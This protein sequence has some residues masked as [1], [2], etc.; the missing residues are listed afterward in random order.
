MAAHEVRSNA[1]MNGGNG[2]GE[3]DGFD[4]LAEIKIDLDDIIMRRRAAQ[5]PIDAQTF[6]SWYS[7]MSAE[8]MARNGGYSVNACHDAKTLIPMA[9]RQLPYKI[10]LA[11]AHQS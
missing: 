9:G 2:G 10:E 8:L 7:M 11:S 5:T 4:S 3:E 1:E 6:T